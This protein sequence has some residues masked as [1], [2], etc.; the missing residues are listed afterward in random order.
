MKQSRYLIALSSACLLLVFFATTP[1]FGTSQT[2]QKWEF[3]FF[4]A[5]DNDWITVWTLHFPPGYWAEY[6]GQTIAYQIGE[7]VGNEIHVVEFWKTLEGQQVPMGWSFEISSDAPLFFR[8]DFAP[9]TLVAASLD[10]NMGVVTAITS[11]QG[12]MPNKIHPYQ[13]TVALAGTPDLDF[14]GTPGERYTNLGWYFRYKVGNDNFGPW[15]KMIR[16]KTQSLKDF[17]HVLIQ[18][19]TIE[20]K[21]FQQIAWGVVVFDNFNPICIFDWAKYLESKGSAM[22]E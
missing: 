1:E 21:T 13:Y 14:R 9:M 19:G 2:A 15:M 17:A 12:T 3:P 4:E 22:K 10:P 20:G 18:T 11:V 6:E 5:T 7:Q 8:V 16:D